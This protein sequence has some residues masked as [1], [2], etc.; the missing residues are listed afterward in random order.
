MYSRRLRK[1]RPSGGP[2]E[3][4]RSGPP[5]SLLS[6]STAMSVSHPRPDV[7]TPKRKVDP[8]TII[9]VIAAVAAALVLFT[10]FRERRPRLDPGA[11]RVRW[12]SI[13]D[14]GS[15][16][17]SEKNPILYDFTAAWCPPCHRLD[18]EGWAD[19]GIADLVNRGYAP[20]CIVDREREDGKNPEAIA[21]LQRRY[22]VEAFP[23][24]IVAA[25]DGTEIARSE[26]YRGR[27][28]LVRFLEGNGTG[29]R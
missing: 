6:S 19:S 4:C 12:Q 10:V 15:A 20:V 5:D 27:A 22:R 8:A 9:V 7:P 21:E 23:T 25:A 26:G 24:L 16:A 13:G 28:F 18:R 29:G 11:G 2:R 1:E 3:R 17:R 14:A